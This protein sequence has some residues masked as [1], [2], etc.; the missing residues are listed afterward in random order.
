[1]SVYPNPPRPAVSVALCTFNGERHLGDQLG[2]IASQTRPPDE[3]VACDDASVDGTV[4]VL[5]RFA[6]SAPFPVRL[7][8]NPCTL[9]S[10][11]NFDQA[12]GR[13][14]GGVAV[15]CDQ[16]DVW[17]P[18]KLRRLAEAFA[19]PAVGLAASDA[20]LIGP[21]GGPLGGRLW[22]A[23]RFPPRE[24]AQVAAGG[25]PRRWLRGNT[26]TGATMAVRTD[27]LPL[28]RPIPPGWVHDGWIAFVAAAVA[29]CRLLGDPL[30]RY[31]LHAGQQI[32]A[33][34]RTLADDWRAARRRDPAHFA[35]VADAFEAL[36]ERLAQHRDR[37]RDPDLVPLLGRKVLFARTQHQM[38]MGGRGRRIGPVA[39]SAWAGDYHLFGRG[40][41][42]LVAD[43]IT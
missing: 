36:A 34:R 17:H 5:E 20:E 18:D 30:T 9:G 6:R 22:D 43:L 2:S 12:L 37:L 10:T 21:A 35:A 31:R 33:R 3:L 42:E 15:L 25:G 11:A 29:D 27:L 28:I 24:R 38:R 4:A 39:R 26:L 16:D 13:C 7:V 41:R 32:G 8:R 14:T 1:M 40:L 23:V 19:D